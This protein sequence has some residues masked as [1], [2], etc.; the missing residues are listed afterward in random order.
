MTQLNFLY[1]Q[2][3]LQNIAQDIVNKSL[4][5]GAT[6]VQVELSES[7]STDLEVLNQQIETLETSHENQLL[8]TVFKGHHKGNVGISSIRNNDLTTIIQQALDIATY[9]EEDPDNGL[10][11]SEYIAPKL[12]KNLNLYIPH[13]IT[14]DELIQETYNLEELARNSPNIKSSDGASTSLTYYNFVTANSNGFNDGYQTSRFSRY[15]SLIGENQTGMQTDY[16]YTSARDFNDLEDNSK[17]AKLA[18]E[19]IIRR[20]NRGEIKSDKPKIIF[21]TQIAKSIIGSLMGAI[22][23]NSQYRKLSFL[24]DSLNSIILPEWISIS[25]DPFVNKGLASCYFDNECGAVKASDIIKNGYL[26]KYLLSSYS[27]R[28]LKMQPTGNAGGTHNLIVSNN[29]NGSLADLAKEMYDGIIIIETIGHG[30]NMVTGDYSVGA[31]G[32]LVKSGIICEYV[33]NLT[34]SGNMKT[35]FNNIALIA[36]DYNHG[37]IL[38]GSMLINEGIIQVSSTN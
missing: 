30:L 25:E 35:I 10:L 26:T 13:N 14:N 9:T 12:E 18:Q 11:E 2:N 31:S 5:M 29:F 8:L 17:I 28:K 27:A 34:I 6:S 1:S 20:L 36:N 32:L 38:C 4:Q 15:V 23:G 7:I 37:S 16:W 3:Q 19:R 24:N 22:S 21:E 33:D